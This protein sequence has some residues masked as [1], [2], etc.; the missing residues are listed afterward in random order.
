MTSKMGQI[1]PK[2]ENMG[3]FKIS[4]ST[5]CLFKTVIKIP[6]FVPLVDKLAYFGCQ[7]VMPDMMSSDQ[8]VS[9]VMEGL[10]PGGALSTLSL[11]LSVTSGQTCT[12]S[13]W[14]SDERLPTGQ[15]WRPPDDRT[16]D[17]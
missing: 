2:W 10:P 5:F 12:A 15:W 14:S 13:Q 6:E 1:G 9:E 7:S 4:F 11:W 8:S 16:E 17:H 3:L